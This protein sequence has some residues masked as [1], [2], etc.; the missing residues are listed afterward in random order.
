MKINIASSEVIHFIGI[1]G[2]GMSGLAEILHNSGY[3][4]FGSDLNEGSNVKKLK[5]LGI[6][7][8]IGHKARNIT[9]ASL[10]VYSSAISKNNPEIVE[11]MSNKIPLVSRAEMLVELMRMK[12]T[13]TVAGSHGKTTTISLISEIFLV[14]GLDPTVVNG[15][16]INSLGSVSYTHLTLPTSRS[17]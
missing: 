1:G 14:S 15:G 7:I 2:I 5:K 8:K 16:I 6:N 12:K 4:V 10:I 17:V 3:Q 11:A 9:G 13:I